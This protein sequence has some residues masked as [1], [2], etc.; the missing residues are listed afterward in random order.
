MAEEPNE[1]QRTYWNNEV[2]VEAWRRREPMTAAVVPILIEHLGLEAGQRVLDVGCGGGR[3]TI[4]AARQVG[5]TGLAIGA[6]VSAPLLELARHRAAADD[7]ANARFTLGDMQVAQLNGAP[8]DL[9]MSQFGVM[10]FD[11]SITAFANI[12]AH[13]RPGGRL[14]FA[15]WQALVDN[16]WFVGPIVARF[17]PPPSTLEAGKSPTGPFAL[18]DR[19]YTSGVL[20][21][22]GWSDIACTP[23]HLTVPVEREAL[24][25]GDPM[26]RFFGVAEDQLG[27]ARSACEQHL[28]PLLRADGG[29]DAPLAFQIF[30]GRT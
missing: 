9:A 10:F 6:D 30:M 13:V 22:A 3:T 29:Y 27:D 11:E 24:L 1:A 25:D 18:A 21:A 8:C 7:V 16:P 2:R 17:L 15:C 4:A 26:L 19:G 20:T 28:A 5:V 12:R 23:C 14:V